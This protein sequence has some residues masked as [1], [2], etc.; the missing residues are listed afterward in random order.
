M[1]ETLFNT[2]RIHRLPYNVQG[3]HTCGRCSMDNIPSNYLNNAQVN[4]T[5]ETKCLA[6]RHKHIGT[7]VTEFRTV[8]QDHTRSSSYA[9]NKSQLDCEKTRISPI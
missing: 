9:A 8:P 4:E 3:I 1:S 6:Q 5:I 7:S 2:I